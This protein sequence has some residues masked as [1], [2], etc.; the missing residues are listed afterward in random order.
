MKHNGRNDPLFYNYN[1]FVFVSANCFMW[2]TKS[3]CRKTERRYK[4]ILSVLYDQRFFLS[5]TQCDLAP[6]SDQAPMT[7]MRLFGC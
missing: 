4:F 6:E 5:V 7:A 1:L 2:L 3:G